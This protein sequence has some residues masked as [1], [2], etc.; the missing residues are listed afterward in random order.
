MKRFIIIFMFLQ[1]GHSSFSQFVVEAPILESIASSQTTIMGTMNITMATI[2]QVEQ[3]ME[4]LKKMAGWIERFESMQEF[5]QLLEST[6]CLAKDLNVEMNIAMNLVGERASCFNEFKYK[7]NINQ[8]RYVVDVVNVV[9]S[10]G[11]SMDRD[12]RL[13]AYKEA[14]SAFEKAQLGLGELSVLLRR[15]IR[16]FEDTR[17][18]REDMMNVN[19]FGRYGRY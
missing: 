12:G 17:R 3:R 16:R 1:I 6:A 18:F 4:T 13:A 11:F 2:R 15:I 10:D 8:L 14:L 7:V 5:V 19:D 9:L